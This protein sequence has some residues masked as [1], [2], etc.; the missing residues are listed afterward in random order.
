MR[1]IRFALPLLILLAFLP[2]FSGCASRPKVDWNS[3]I[4]NYTYNQA[5]LEMGPPDGEVTLNDGRKVAQWILGRSA[6]SGLTVGFGGISGH[7]GVGVSQ[8]VGSGFRDQ[9]LRLTFGPD[10]NLAEWNRN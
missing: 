2:L 10:G 9:V 8:S 1:I 5:V 4:G 3:R 6:G 7:T